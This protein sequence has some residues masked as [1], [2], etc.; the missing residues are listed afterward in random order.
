MYVFGLLCN[1][2]ACRDGGIIRRNLMSRP[3]SLP[4][5]TASAFDSA[6][7]LSL[8]DYTKDI[9]PSKL[10]KNFKKRRITQGKT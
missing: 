5:K 1:K 10:V 2:T 8:G 4:E 9:K 6:V 7:K 3:C